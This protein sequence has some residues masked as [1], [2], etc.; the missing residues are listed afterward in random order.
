MGLHPIK[1]T[2]PIYQDAAK[3]SVYHPI[4]GTLST[5][6]DAVKQRMKG[7]APQRQI[8]G[9][10]IDRNLY[11]TSAHAPNDMVLLV[12]HGHMAKSEATE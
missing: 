11:I 3:Q 6:Q 8:Y 1:G 7:S 2:P 10:S 5:Y 9:A 4:K 12:Q